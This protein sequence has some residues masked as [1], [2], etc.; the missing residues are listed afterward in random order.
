MKAADKRFT[1]AQMEYLAKISQGVREDRTRAT[2]VKWFAQDGFREAY[3]EAVQEANKAD[4]SLIKIAWSH[5]R[6]ASAM[7][8]D[9][10]T[11]REESW[12]IKMHLEVSNAVIGFPGEDQ[13]DW[14][15]ALEGHRME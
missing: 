3:V 15:A 6:T 11:T 4:P 13:I 2:M 9:P 10:A 5:L 7:T 8:D 1:R 14:E 12:R